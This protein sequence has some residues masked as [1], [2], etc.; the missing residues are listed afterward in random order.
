MYTAVFDAVGFTAVFKNV[1][2]LPAIDGRTALSSGNTDMFYTA[3]GR[4][5]RAVFAFDDGI[6]NRIVALVAATGTAAA[7]VLPRSRS[8]KRSRLRQTT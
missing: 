5:F 7:T 6:T 4:A 1:C 2:I 8:R 3:T